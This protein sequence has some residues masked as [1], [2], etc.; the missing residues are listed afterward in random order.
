MKNDIKHTL[1]L[2]SPDGAQARCEEKAALLEADARLA[3]N[4]QLR[5]GDVKLEKWWSMA[6]GMALIAAF[7]L[8]SCYLTIPAV[9][10]LCLLAAFLVFVYVRRYRQ[11]RRIENAEPEI[12]PNRCVETFVKKALGQPVSGRDVSGYMDEGDIA[13]FG[14]QLRSRLAALGLSAENVSVKSDAKVTETDQTGAKCGK[15]PV[16]VVLDCAGAKVELKWTAAFALASTGDC[17]LDTKL[18][19]E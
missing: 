17:M 6:A 15:M 12:S 3:E 9:I 4:A 1:N 7:I 11:R 19:I 18:D 16:R 2:T 13:A 8:Y 10:L 14:E 5:S